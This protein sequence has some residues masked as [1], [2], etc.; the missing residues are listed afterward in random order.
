MNLMILFL[1]FLTLNLFLEFSL[2]LFHL[3]EFVVVFAGEILDLDFPLYVVN[4]RH[5]LENQVFFI[6]IIQLKSDA[7]ILFV[8][9]Q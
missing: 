3:L 9:L 1:I 5:L 2:L 8:V 6:V 4:V 7:Q